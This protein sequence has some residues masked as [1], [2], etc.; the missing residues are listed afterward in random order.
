[1]AFFHS[2]FLLFL[3]FSPYPSVVIFSLPPL[4]SFYCPLLFFLPKSISIFIPASF[5]FHFLFPFLALFSLSFYFPPFSLSFYFPPS[6][7]LFSLFIP[8]SWEDI[9]WGHAGAQN[10]NVRR[11]FFPSNI[12]YV[13]TNNEVINTTSHAFIKWHTFEPT[14]IDSFETKE[15]RYFYQPCKSI[16]EILSMTRIFLCFYCAAFVVLG[17]DQSLAPRFASPHCGSDQ[18]GIRT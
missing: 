16:R 18:P 1:M 7:L 9:V 12:H 15:S 11:L 5:Y 13:W 14:L 3:S 8:S 2:F 6:S 10:L 4:S 17:D